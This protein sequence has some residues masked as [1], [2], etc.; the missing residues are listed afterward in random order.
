MQKKHK[1]LSVVLVFILVII[2]GFFVAQW[3][4]G[5]KIEQALS[6][7]P[8]HIQMSYSNLEVNI[9]LGNVDLKSSKW[10]V[11]GKTTG[12][13]ITQGHIGQ[14]SIENLSYWD[15]LFNEKIA[16]ETLLIQNPVIKYVQNNKVKQADFEQKTWGSLTQKVELGEVL[17]SKADVLVVKK[18][19]DSLLFSSPNVNL[20]VDGLK[21]HKNENK[22]VEF[23][24][25]SVDAKNIKYALNDYDDVFVDSLSVTKTASFLNNVKIKTKFD[26]AAFSQV[27]ETERDHV[28]I[29]FKSVSVTGQDLKLLNSS[30]VGI[31]AERVSVDKPH[32]EIYRDKLVADDL[33][34]KPLYGKMLRNLKFN[35]GIDTLNINQGAIVYSEKVKKDNGAGRI[36]FTNFNA[37]IANLGN[38]YSSDTETLIEVNTDFMEGSP[39]QVQWHFKVQD[40]TDRFVFKAD[41][42]HITAASMNSFS[43][44]NLNTRF[45][46]ELYQTFFTIDGNPKLSSIDLKIKYDNFK[47]SMLKE[48]GWEKKKFLSG[49]INWF[50]SNDSKEN[51]DGYRYGHAEQVERDKTKSVFNFIWLSIRSGLRSAIANDGEKEN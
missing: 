3:K 8:N 25:F 6:E 16:V 1:I 42:G 49:L 29:H 19:N 48:D 10:K 44:P 45:N 36:N 2:V 28:D 47:V 50:I 26:K 43:E 33:E 40:S 17:V 31:N 11:Y 46:G 37:T 13:L 41:L 23:D 51:E 35:L 27:V 30:V 20:K 38:S 22:P 12:E 15:C 34:P 14:I 7:F 39:L 5:K 21:F 4:I 32:F 24:G 18:D 9:L